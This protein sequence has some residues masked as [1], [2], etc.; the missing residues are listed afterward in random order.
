MG[1]K[2]NVNYI[3]CNK[4]NLK[5]KMEWILNKGNRIKV[6]E[7]RLN[8]MNLVR[9]YH[10]TSHRAN[11]FNIIIDNKYYKKTHISNQ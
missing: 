5:S 7:I 4:E 9:N 8:G 10:S 6:D 2:N 3:S 1:F 11:L